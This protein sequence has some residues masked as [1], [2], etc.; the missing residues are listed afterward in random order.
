MWLLGKML[1]A[2][3]KEGQL[4]VRDYDGKLYTYGDPT[5]PPLTIRFTDK[6]AALHVAKDPRVGAG[7]AYMDGRMVIE[8][9]HDVR[10]FVLLVMRNANRGHG[11]VEAPSALKRGLDWAMAKAD[12]INLRPKASSNVTHHYDLTRQFYELFLDTDRQY[13]HSLRMRTGLFLPD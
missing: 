9:P 3:I 12:Q 7:E 10:D 4:Q 11:S 6:G 1:S 8:P 2:L 13:N 5:A